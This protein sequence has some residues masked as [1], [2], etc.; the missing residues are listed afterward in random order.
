MA[1]YGGMTVNERLVVAGLN[2]SFDG[3]ARRRDRHKMI[4]ILA[5]VEM[6]PDGAAKVADTV[7]ANPARYG[8]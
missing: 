6:T 4:E 7:L 1:E 2:G 5:A 8:L 3:A